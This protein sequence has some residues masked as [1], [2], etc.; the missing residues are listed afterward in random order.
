MKKI[1]LV[2]LALLASSMTNGLKISSK[3]KAQGEAGW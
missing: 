2:I 3:I 1:S